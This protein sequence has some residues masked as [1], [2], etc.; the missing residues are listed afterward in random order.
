MKISQ[1]RL[2]RLKRWYKQCLRKKEQKTKNKTRM[3]GCLA[4]QH[5]EQFWPNLDQIT[6]PSVECSQNGQLM[7]AEKQ[8]QATKG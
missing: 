7:K 1:Q 5:L 2:K 8:T 6:A 3:E 4:S